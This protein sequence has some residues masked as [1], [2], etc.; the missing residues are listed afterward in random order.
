MPRYQLLLPLRFAAQLP[1]VGP[2]SIHEGLIV[3]QIGVPEHLSLLDLDIRLQMRLVFENQA[4]LAIRDEI[5]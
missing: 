5:Y 2:C 4:S 3:C 1:L